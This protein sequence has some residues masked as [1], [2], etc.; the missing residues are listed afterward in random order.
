MVETSSKLFEYISKYTS[1]LL[2]LSIAMKLTVEKAI[3]AY[4]HLSVRSD[5]CDHNSLF[6]LFPPIS[7]FLSLS[8]NIYFMGRNVKISLESNSRNIQLYRN[9]Q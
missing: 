8:E 5:I 1:A 3:E 7:T 2:F 4:F 9:T 6:G